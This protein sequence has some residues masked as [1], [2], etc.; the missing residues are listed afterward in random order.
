MSA[1][2]AMTHVTCIQTAKMQLDPMNAHALKI[3]NILD[4]DFDAQV[5]LFASF[6]QIIS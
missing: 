3:M 6:I 5:C 1:C 2:C 4:L